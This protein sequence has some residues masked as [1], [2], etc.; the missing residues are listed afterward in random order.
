MVRQY[1]AGDV[2]LDFGLKWTAHSILHANQ[3]VALPLRLRSGHAGRHRPAQKNVPAEK[4]TGPHFDAPTLSVHVAFLSLLALQTR[5]SHNWPGDKSRL[6][7][8]LWRHS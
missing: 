8:G 1:V 5:K 7:F 2:M 6:L 3:Q 4:A